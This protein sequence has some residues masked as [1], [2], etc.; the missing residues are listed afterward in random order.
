MSTTI[1]P[2]YRTAPAQS[3]G[4]P[5]AVI[6]HSGDETELVNLTWGLR[7]REEGGRAFT[8]IRS[9]GRHFPANRCLLPASEFHFRRNGSRYRFTLSN[10][11]WFY[12]AGIWRPAERDWPEAYAVLTTEANA[13]VAPYNDRQMAVLRRGDHL[14]WLNERDEAL[15]RPLPAGSFSVK[16]VGGPKAG[17]RAFDW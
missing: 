4:E 8:V 15:L 1:D 9:E 2:G 17:Q 12:F 6:R 7:P 14:K 11:D 13:D 16:C 3:A 5:G 10:G